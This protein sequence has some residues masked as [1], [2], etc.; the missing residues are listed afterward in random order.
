MKSFDSVKPRYRK[1]LKTC[2][3]SGFLTHALKSQDGEMNVD[4]FPQMYQF[5]LECQILHQLRSIS[6]MTN[7]TIIY[8][9]PI[10]GT[11]HILYHKFQKK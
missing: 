11:G 2:T 10:Q 3:Q 7:D 6:D 5:K 1:K 8:N 4:N 9:V